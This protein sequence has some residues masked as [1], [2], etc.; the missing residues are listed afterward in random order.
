M[1]T[2]RVGIASL[3]QFRDYTMAIARGEH[4]RASDEPKL[5]CSSIYGFAKLLSER[6]RELLRVIGET[7]P[8]SLDE[9]AEA[10]GLA[11]SKLSRTLKALERHGLVQ[12][13]RGK[14]RAM[15]P[16]AAYTHVVLNLALRG[17]ASARSL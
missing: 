2:L 5:W 6:N 14:G 4:K 3:E 16:R 7:K 12:F 10:T 15:V 9:L 13:R 1:T 11:K 8:R 17:S